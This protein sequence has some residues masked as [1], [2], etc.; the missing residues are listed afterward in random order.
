MIPKSVQR[1]SEKIM[2]S[3]KKLAADLIS[4]ATYCSA[5]LRKAGST[6][7]GARLLLGTHA[8]RG[9]NS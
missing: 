3:D 9:R 1:F 5:A 4:A 7:W 6:T 2:L 8:V